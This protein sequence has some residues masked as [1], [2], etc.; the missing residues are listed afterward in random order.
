MA[1]ITTLKSRTLEK[2]GFE[3]ASETVS[4]SDSDKALI[5]LQSAHY[6]LNTE[7]LLRWTMNDIPSQLEEP[8]VMLA[9]Y[10]IGGEFGLPQSDTLY[11]KAMK[12]IR[13][14]VMTEKSSQPAPSESF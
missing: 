11:L 12:Q 7:G 10:N 14:F 3:G 2:I 9:A 13:A 4:D 5:G 1:D 8:Y 6:E